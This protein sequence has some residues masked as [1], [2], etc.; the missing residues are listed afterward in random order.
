[1]NKSILDNLIKPKTVAVF[2][3]SWC[4]YCTYTKNSLNKMGIKYTLFEMDKETISKTDVDRL[5]TMCGFTSV[6]KIFVG[7]NCIGGNSELQSLIS[8]G[9]FK[10]MLEEEGI[11]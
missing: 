9:E 8:S 10:E 4:P 1:M 7:M 11:K 5:N 6:P 3:K 2:S